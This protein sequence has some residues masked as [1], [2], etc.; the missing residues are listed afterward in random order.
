MFTDVGGLVQKGIAAAKAGDRA[1]AEQALM[2][3]IKQN[4]QNVRAW[5]WLAK[6]VDSSKRQKVLEL[7]RNAAA[8]QGEQGYET[9]RTLLLEDG[10][11]H[12]RRYR[13]AA[14]SEPTG[15]KCPVCMM[16]MEEDEI[17]IECPLCKREHHIECWEDN[18]YHC[19]NFGC[20]GVGLIDYD[21]PILVAVAGQEGPVELTV[22]DIP[23]ESPYVSVSTQER[24]AQVR[25]QVDSNPLN[26]L[27]R[28]LATGG[29]AT[30]RTT[31]QPTGDLNP[32]RPPQSHAINDL[33]R[34]QR[35]QADQGLLNA[36]ERYS[37]REL[38]NMRERR[39][40]QIAQAR[41]ERQRPAVRPS[42]S[43]PTTHASEQTSA[44]SQEELQ[45]RVGQ[46]ALLGLIP[47][48]MFAIV[49]YQ[50]SSSIW[51][52]VLT[53]LIAAGAVTTVAQQATM[54]Q[55]SNRIVT[56]VYYLLPSLAAAAMMMAIY[57]YSDKGWLSAILGYVL[58]IGVTSGILTI[59]QVLERQAFVAYSSLALTALTIVSLLLE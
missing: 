14:E 27:A 17:V 13:L 2:A 43:R 22:D 59:P 47:G 45:D 31:T 35:S 24:D 34:P 11:P 39:Q 36:L 40:Q 42:S 57:E 18:V 7:A 8:N 9:M 33:R 1:T 53:A 26:A 30:P 21:S 29:L 44:M 41:R 6:V 37:D 19:G 56:I 54:P 49:M 48:I 28:A 16:E 12:L 46:A 20:S 32:I 3:A 52:A 50:Y 4:E 51:M 23:T 15:D 25:R 10:V 5:W 38:D 58:G 55:Q